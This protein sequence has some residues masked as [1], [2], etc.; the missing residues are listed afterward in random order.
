LR[1]PD[2]TSAT[3]P[4]D[5]GEHRPAA[6]GGPGG[7][8]KRNG[9]GRAN[10]ATRVSPTARRRVKRTV[11]VIVAAF[12]IN[13]LVLPQLARLGDAIH[14]LT[15][16]R[17]SFLVLGLALQLASIVAYSQL[18]REALPPGSISLPLMVRIQFATRALANIVPG[19][20][21]A[22]ATLG[23]R[24]LTLSGVRGSD[25]GFALATAGLGSA[26]LLN[27]ILWAGLLISIPLRGFSPLYVTAAVIGV[28][29]IGVFFGIVL[30]LVHGREQAVKVVQAVARKLRLNPDRAAQVVER[31]A[32]RIKDLYGDKVLLRRVITWGL[33]SWLLNAASLWI[34]LFA[35]D[36]KLSLD[37]LLVSFGLA[38]LFAAIPITPGGLGIVE[39]IYI[40]TLVAFGVPPGVAV[41]AVPLYRLA[42][43]WLPTLLGGF[44]YLSLRLGPFAIKQ[45]E[46]LERLRDVAVEAIEHPASSI[47]WAETYGQRPAAPTEDPRLPPPAPPPFQS[48]GPG[49]EPPDLPPH[50]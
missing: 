14:Q 31:L 1:V 48:P 28:F 27:I 36:V 34:F 8:A 15:S 44:A 24:L 35:F 37:G 20:N 19:G 11:Q 21:A 43:Y 22:A 9:N 47:D 29:L 4:A 25:A 45:G 12:A 3:V 18:T 2:A 5:D 30:S 17:S 23:Y 32:D 49:W 42:Q 41:I 50:R 13:Y 46:H 16:I 26:V 33:V 38:N 7:P 6:V 10:G 40:P 39:S